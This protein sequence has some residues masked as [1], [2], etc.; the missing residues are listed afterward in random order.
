MGISTHVLN[1]ATGR[2]AAG[3][4]VTL[5]YDRGGF[6]VVCMGKTNEDGRLRLVEAQPE[7]GTYRITFETG[8]YFRGET[9]FPVAAITF[10][11]RDASQHYHVPLLVSPYGYSTYRG[12]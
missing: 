8:A 5:E 4:A 11:V 3:I 7:P 6:D 10:E 9:F 1:T 12:S 2:P